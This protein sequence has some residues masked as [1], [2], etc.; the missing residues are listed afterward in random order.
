[1][2]E[3]IFE[4]DIY[5]APGA[6]LS[7]QEG[8]KRLPIGNDNFRA[9]IRESVFIDKSLLIADVLNRGTAVTLYCR[10]RR[11]GKSLNLSMLQAFFEAENPSDPA[12]RDPEQLFR[13]LEIWEAEDGRYR[14]YAAGYPVVRISLNNAKD[15]TWKMALGAIRSNMAAEFDRHAYLQSSESLTEEQ[16]ELFRRISARSADDEELKSS[17]LL[18]TQL[19]MAHHGTPAVVL[20]D[21]YDAP[22]MAAATNGYYR[23]AVDFLKG[24]LTGALKSNPA[25]AFGVLTGVQ[26]ISKESIFSDLNNLI[27]DTSMSLASDERYGFTQAEVEALATYRGQ[28]GGIELARTWYDGY[29]F[30]A[31]DVYNPWSTLNFFQNNCA[32]D[33]YWTNT[34]GNGVLGE[35]AATSDPKTL[36]KLYQLLEPDGGIEEPIDTSTVFADAGLPAGEAV[37]SLLYLAGYLTTDD[38]QLPNDNELLRRLRIPNREVQRVFSSEV[39]ARFARQAGGRDRLR[40]LHAALRDGDTEIVAEELEDVLLNSASHFDL[41]R[42]NSYH[43]LMLG[44]MFGMRGYGDPLSNREAGRGRFDIRIQP[45]DPDSNPVLI[46]ELKWARPDSPEA[47]D[48]PILAEAAL[49]QARERTYASNAKPGAAGTVLWGIA[50][51]GKTLAVS[52]SKQ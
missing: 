13:G 2:S 7:D 45:E 30:G 1:M 17:L 37:W 26:R 3:G 41:L 16:Q 20:I 40:E 39:I 28:E 35:L 25:L 46:L 33:L 22:V 19:L 15:N 50:F 10:P 47:S 9:L 44:L 5:R 12:W 29:R 31:V 34:S 51:S 14:E 18:L 32:P 52:C 4:N 48:L 49:T 23:E 36:E 6:R 24:W 38:T 42:E 8:I 27:V 43:M 11:F 21:E